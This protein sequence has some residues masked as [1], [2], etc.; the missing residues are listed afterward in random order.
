MHTQERL[1]AEQAGELHQHLCAGDTSGVAAHPGLARFHAELDDCPE[2]KL[3]DEEFCPWSA[4]FDRSEWHVIMSCVWPRADAV[5]ELV[6]RLAAKH[7]LAF[8]DPQSGRILQPGDS[9]RSKPWW[10][11]W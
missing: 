6:Q 5:G 10:K 8:Y 9:L 1:S 7:G 2:D 4:A 11:F 3:D